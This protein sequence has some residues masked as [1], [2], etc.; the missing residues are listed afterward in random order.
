MQELETKRDGYVRLSF[1]DSAADPIHVMAM[2]LRGYCSI[3]PHRS[4][5][6][7][8]IIYVVLDGCLTFSH[9]E[10]RLNEFSANELDE[11]GSIYVVDR[12]KWRILSNNNCDACIYLEITQGPFRSQNTSWNWK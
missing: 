8:K 7:G 11:K 1:H 6:P 9:A 5:S 10:N 3:I 12:H 4:S 2:A